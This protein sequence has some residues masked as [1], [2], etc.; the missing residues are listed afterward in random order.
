MN[1]EPPTPLRHDDFFSEEA[2]VISP[3]RTPIRPNELC[4]PTTSMDVAS[5]NA[6][7]PTV[8]SEDTSLGGRES[9]SREEGSVEDDMAVSESVAYL[10]AQDSEE[11]SKDSEVFVHSA[12]T[13]LG[14]SR[15]GFEEG[16]EEITQEKFKSQLESIKLEDGSEDVEITEKRMQE[17]LPQVEQAEKEMSSIAGLQS[18]AVLTSANMDKASTEK[19]VQKA[20]R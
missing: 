8:M 11:A 4:L 10:E 12:V 13:G 17:I 2:S 16:E 3:T 18:E 5:S 7:P 9:C 1:Y 20:S 6:E 14:D 15:S 19:P